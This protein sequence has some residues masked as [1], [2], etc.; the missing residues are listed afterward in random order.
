MSVYDCLNFSFYSSVEVVYIKDKRGYARSHK[1]ENSFSRAMYA[2]HLIAD[3]TPTN[4][5]QRLWVNSI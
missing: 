5:R 3:Q 2:H 1:I 4:E